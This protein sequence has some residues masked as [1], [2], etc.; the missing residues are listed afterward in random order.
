MP[1]A[2][3][4]RP[5]PLPGGRDADGGA[6]VFGG[7]GQTRGPAESGQVYPAGAGRCAGDRTESVTAV[8]AV[9]P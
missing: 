7:P 6:A 4:L 3:A 5:C 8:C 9:L 1:W 2:C